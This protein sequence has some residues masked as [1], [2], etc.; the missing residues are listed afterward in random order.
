[1][2]KTKEKQAQSNEFNKIVSQRLRNAIDKSGLTQA[3]IV[4]KCSVNGFKIS[5]SALS[6]MLSESSPSGFTL[7]NV[8]HISNVL[9]LDLNQLLSTST[10]CDISLSN[11]NEESFISHKESP[12]LQNYVGQYHLL[13]Y[14][15]ISD[16]TDPIE[17][18]L[19]IRKDAGSMQLVVQIKIEVDRNYTKSK[20]KKEYFGSLRLSTKRRAIYITCTNEKLCEDIFIILPYIVLDYEKLYSCLG[21]ALVSSA[22]TNR[23][24]TA[25]RILIT[26]HKLSKTQKKIALGQLLLNKADIRI[27]AEQ[28]KNMLGDPDLPDSFRKIFVKD[29]ELNGAMKRVYYH[30]NE[31][32]IRGSDLNLYDRMM[33]TALLRYYSDFPKYAKVS[34]KANEL[35]YRLLKEMDI[36]EKSDDLASSE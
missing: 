3:E 18:I 2:A 34:S 21:M 26:E 9:C 6:K 15:T 32:T 29:D 20:I 19:D 10:I 8:A 22:G 11:S 7:A 24:P 12:F 27:S 25:Q 28:F 4:E 33:S 16:E 35:T 13:M 14:R 17:G 23:V 31:A 1:M 36:E 30:I 5:N